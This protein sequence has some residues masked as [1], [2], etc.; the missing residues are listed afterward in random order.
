LYDK[1]IIVFC[2]DNGSP[3]PCGKREIY[4]SGLHL[5]FIVRFPKGANA[6][7][8]SQ[9]ISFVDLAPTTLSLVG[10]KPPEYMQGQAFLGS[11]KS[12]PRK[13]IFGSGDRFDKFSDRIRIVRDNRYLFVKNYH[14]ELPPYKD[15][16]YRKH[17]DM[18]ME[19]LKLRDNGKLIKIR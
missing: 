4:D 16:R 6:G 11:Y 18:M 8:V 3:L 1:T 10:I 7:R 14:P 17:M 9:M 2:S 19:L 5:P 13:Y 12:A 15:V